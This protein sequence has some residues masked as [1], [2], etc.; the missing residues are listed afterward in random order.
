MRRIQPRRT[1]FSRGG[2]KASAPPGLAQGSPALCP[3]PAA[4]FSSRPWLLGWR[5]GQR[6]RPSCFIIEENPEN[7]R[8]IPP[9]SLTRQR[10]VQRGGS[11]VPAAQRRKGA[12]KRG[13]SG[14]PPREMA[15]CR[16]L[17]A[18]KRKA[19]PRAGGGPSWF[20]CVQAA[21]ATAA[22]SG[23]SAASG[24]PGPASRYRPGRGPGSASWPTSRSQRPRR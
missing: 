15:K 6:L 17:N 19:H 13:G 3:T 12:F 2:Q 5:R 11:G 4:T 14:D 8:R 18:S 1:K 9:L 24:W 20:I 22:A 16:S 21:K 23:P 7:V 10:Y